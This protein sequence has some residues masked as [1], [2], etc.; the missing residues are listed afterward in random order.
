MHQ[1]YAQYAG[2][3]QG[4]NRFRTYFRPSF[5][6][7][8]MAVKTRDFRKSPLL[9]PPSDSE[10]PFA[11]VSPADVGRM[12]VAL[13]SVMNFSE[14]LG[15][16]G[17]SATLIK[18]G[19]VDA[20][21]CV[22]GEAPARREMTQAKEDVHW[23]KYI[24]YGRFL[25][26]LGHDVGADVRANISGIKGLVDDWRKSNNWIGLELVVTAKEAGAPVDEMVSGFD[27]D[28]LMQDIK[29]AKP[30]DKREYQWARKLANMHTLG[31]D[32]SELIAENEQM[33]KDGIAR[34]S[35]GETRVLID[36]LECMQDLGLLTQTKQ[37]D[38]ADTMPP[39]KKLG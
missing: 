6:V 18:L 8:N 31:F 39:I 11:E 21:D 13:K 4:K 17:Y 36:Y 38:F 34:H 1:E 3:K 20:H 37:K 29:M 7:V 9:S 27:R 25:T 32:V 16:C 26:A 2:T 33:L 12:R 30:G 23:E 14:P 28:F 24:K 5:P 22:D 10:S 35:K 15:Y 19:V